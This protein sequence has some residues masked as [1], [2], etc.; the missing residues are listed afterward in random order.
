MNNNTN[1][2]T[3]CERM[4]SYITAESDVTGWP[5]THKQDLELDFDILKSSS[6]SDEFIWVLKKSGTYLISLKKGKSPSYVKGLK[7]N[8][9]RWYH[10]TNLCLKEIEYEKALNLIEQLPLQSITKSDFPMVSELLELN[11]QSGFSSLDLKTTSDTW[12][13]WLKW[14]ESNN[15]YVMHSL[16]SKALICLNKTN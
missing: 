12:S 2:S 8:S 7:E 16:I 4:I 14:F 9:N 10:L 11:R 6:S 13:D 1:T 5:E 3:A 15:N